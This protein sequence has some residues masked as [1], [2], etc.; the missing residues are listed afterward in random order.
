M[1]FIVEQDELAHPIDVGALRAFRVVQLAHLRRDLT[2][3][4]SKAIWSHL[5]F[6]WEIPLGPWFPLAEC[7]LPDLVAFKTK[8]FDE[9]VSHDGLQGI[10]R[11]LE[12]ERVWELKK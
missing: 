2:T 11:T 8:A 12:I 4:E 6:R 10:L 7:K 1:P 9:A 5:R 3:E